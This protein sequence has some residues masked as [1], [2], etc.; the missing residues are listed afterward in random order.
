MVSD[1]PRTLRDHGLH[2]G[3]TPLE[4]PTWRPAPEMPNCP[5]CDADVAEVKLLME[6][7]FVK[8]GT[9]MGTYYGCPACP[10]ASPVIVVTL[11]NAEQA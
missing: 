11:G 3:G 1:D 9:G 8:G 4:R 5:N 10:W 7:E 2:P 6:N